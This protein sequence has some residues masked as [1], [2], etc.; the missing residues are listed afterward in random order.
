MRS[1]TT[2]MRLILN[3]HS[4]LDIPPESH[5]LARLF[6]QV[7]PY[8]PLTE[9]STEQALSVV[10]ASPEWRRD[11]HGDE[12][13]LRARV[14]KR[15]P[16]TVAAFI[17]EV[18][19]LQIEPTGKPAWG[20]KTPAYLFQ[21]ERLR[22]CFP[23]ARFIAMV[24]DPRDVFLSL[25][26]RE[27]VGQ[28]TWQVGHYLRRCDRLVE[29]HETTDPHF[30]IVRYEDLVSEPE[31]SV[32]RVCSLLALD[33]E[34]EMLTFYENAAQK[35]Q[36]WELDIGVHQ[37]LLRPMKPDDVSRWKREGA[38][39]DIREVE[40]VC[41]EAINRFGYERSIPRIEVPMLATRSRLRHHIARRRRI[42][43]EP[44]ASHVADTP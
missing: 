41:W 11:W 44:G 9:E 18:F 19:R 30:S 38:R 12:A 13:E 28:S 2:L 24:R 27:W 5:F 10:V 36:Q 37:K 21:T 22:A 20:D 6:R 34:P 23:D 3:R 14:D 25:A 1:G 26:P 4:E 33:F 8:Q 40:A 42:K 32:R 29:Q 31:T 17:D 35:V 16:N 15:Q 39:R 43:A 7:T